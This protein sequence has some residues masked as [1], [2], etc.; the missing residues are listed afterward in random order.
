MH[1]YKDAIDGSY[2]MVSAVP[3]DDPRFVAITEGEWDVLRQAGSTEDHPYSPYTLNR[4]AMEAASRDHLPPDGAQ[5]AD[6]PPS[7]QPGSEEPV[8]GVID[9]E[10]R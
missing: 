7:E 6:P 4:E 9:E 2:P 10:I 3:L 8:A 1:Y 5:I